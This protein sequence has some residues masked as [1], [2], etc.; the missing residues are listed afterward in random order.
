MRAN[1]LTPEDYAQE[2]VE[3]WPEHE[4]AVTLFCRLSTQWR[5]GAGG[6]TGLD[7]AAIYP[8]MDR[9]GLPPD[10]WDLLLAD[11]Q[12]LERAALSEMNRKTD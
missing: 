5:V 9:L 7:Y 1:G 2:A 10:E 12:V 11:V 6:A 4:Q 8:L 3:Y